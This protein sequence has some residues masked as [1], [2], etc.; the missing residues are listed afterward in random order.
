MHY[1][2]Q[3]TNSKPAGGYTLSALVLLLSVVAGWLPLETQAQQRSSQA[4]AQAFEMRE[5]QM[6]LQATRRELAAVKAQ[7]SQY[8]KTIAEAFRVGEEQGLKAND[9]HEKL[10]ALGVDLLSNSDENLQQRLI[11][12]VRDINILQQESDRQRKAIHELSEAFL[13]YLAQTPNVNEGIKAEANTAIAKS[14][15]ALKPLVDSEQNGATPLNKSQIISYNDKLSL[16]VLN[17]GKETG[18]RI[19]TPISIWRNDR[20]L[21]S[22]IIINVRESISGALLQADIA[23][24]GPPMVGDKIRP[25]TSQDNF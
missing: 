2:R 23:Q 13:K 25:I 15:K 12:A 8:K 10:E 14:A 5:L 20:V 17:A 11:K 7:N 4:Q 19:G 16:I 21:Y 24:V 1:Q 18:V 3:I 9:L 6:A 22:A